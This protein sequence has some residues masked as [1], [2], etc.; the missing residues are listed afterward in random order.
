MIRK[1]LIAANGPTPNEKDFRSATLA[2]DFLI[3]ADGGLKHFHQFQ[4]LPDLVIGDLDSIDVDLL[5]TY[6]KQTEIYKFPCDKNFTDLELAMFEAEKRGAKSLEIYSW[7][8]ERLDYSLNSLL[9]AASLRAKV[10]FFS[11]NSQISIL[12]YSH[13]KFLFENSG[14]KL[15]IFPLSKSVS[16]KT[17]GLRWELKWSKVGPETRSQSNQIASQG[18]IQLSSG[19]AFVLIEK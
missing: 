13:P 4:I 2:C 10:D 14:K 9:A 6:Q 12:N 19:S 15:S 5:A 16:L 17:S 1:A 8:D 3:A 11:P 18:F 7:A